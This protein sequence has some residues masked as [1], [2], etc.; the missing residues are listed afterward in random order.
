MSKLNDIQFNIYFNLQE[1]E[2]PCCKCVMVHSDLLTNLIKLRKLVNEPIFIN[3][4][5]RCKTYNNQVGGV[6]TSYHLFGMA[7]DVYARNINISSLAIHA[8]QVGFK[9]IGVYGTF[10]HLDVRPEKYIWEG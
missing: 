4:G 10:L 6:A 3:S 1:F 7:V 9:G 2:C 8:Q 5:Y